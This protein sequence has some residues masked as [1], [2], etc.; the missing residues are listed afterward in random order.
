MTRLLDTGYDGP[1]AIHWSRIIYLPPPKISERPLSEKVKEWV[2]LTDLESALDEQKEKI[3]KT[4]VKECPIP[5]CS[6]SFFNE[7]AH[8]WDFHPDSS[9]RYWKS[10]PEASFVT[11]DQTLAPEE[12][13]NPKWQINQTREIDEDKEKDTT[14]AATTKQEDSAESPA[15]DSQTIYA[16]NRK[17]DLRP[18]YEIVQERKT[19]DTTE[20][21]EPE[22]E[23]ERKK[24]KK[25]TINPLPM[26]KQRVRSAPNIHEEELDSSSIKM[27]KSENTIE[28]DESE[29]QKKKKMGIVELL[30]MTQPAAKPHEKRSNESPLKE[31]N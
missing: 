19:K 26:E 25:E 11:N 10:G 7:W 1:E 29:S 20:A 3:Q 14:E 30:P 31:M 27:K 16:S 2:K 8:R 23:P 18:T 12:E 4:E 28:P 5:R 6:A 9:S 13:S 17:E 22:S 15:K 21:H 24:K